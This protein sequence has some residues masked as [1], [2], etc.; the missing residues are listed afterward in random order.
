[1]VSY[2]HYAHELRTVLATAAERGE[3]DI[4]VDAGNLHHSLSA[5]YELDS[6]CW[7]AMEAAM[8]EGDKVEMMGISIRY[9]LPRPH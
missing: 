4:L 3:S 6:D 5:R 7:G 9:R 1:M 8:S 2:D